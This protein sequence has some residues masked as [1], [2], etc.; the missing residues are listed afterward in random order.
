[1]RSKLFVPASRPELYAKALASAADAISLDL[2]DAVEESRKGEARALLSSWLQSDAALQAGKALIVRCNAADTPHFRDDV[3]AA[4]WPALRQL[5]LPMVEDPQSVVEAAAL[6]ERIER[7]RGIAQPIGILANI[8]SPAGLRRAADIARAHPRIAGLQ[9]GF[10]D[11]LSPL[12]IRQGHPAMVQHVRMQVRLAAGEAGIDAYD[13]A[14]VDIKNPDGYRADA[15]AARDLGFSGKSCIHP[16]QVALANEVFLP[17]EAEVAH[18]LRVVE[19][20]RE[21]LSKGTGAFVVDGRLVDGPFIISAQRLVE[22]ARR[23]GMI[24]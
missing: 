12:G 18:A 7:E 1:M 17:D 2:E 11:L 16:T 10:G 6:L 15:Q 19:A 24:A 20:A 9:I 8:E 22:T 3:Q 4:A 13:G 14:Y 21:Q 5:N 23:A